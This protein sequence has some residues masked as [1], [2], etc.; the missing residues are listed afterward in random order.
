MSVTCTENIFSQ[1]IMFLYCK[2][3]ICLVSK[4]YNRFRQIPI[5]LELQITAV[6]NSGSK[7][8]KIV[9]MNVFKKHNTI[10]KQFIF[11]SMIFNIKLHS[12]YSSVT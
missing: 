2:S 12:I 7:F 3:H 6:K 10:P 5:T 8:L 1:F 11:V 4:F 9:F